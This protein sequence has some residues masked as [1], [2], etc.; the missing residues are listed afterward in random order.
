MDDLDRAIV[1]ALQDGV[2]VCE[3]PFAAA[4]DALGIGE[5]ALI[6]HLRRL[7][8]GGVLTRFGPMFDAERLGG[9]VSLAAMSVPPERLDAVAAQV[10]GF[11]EVAHN[12]ER[13]HALNLWFVLATEASDAI[14]RVIEAIASHT[15][16][17]V[18]DMPKLEEYYIGL[19][20]RT[21]KDPGGT[22]VKHA[23]ETTAS[24]AG[25]EHPARDAPMR[26]EGRVGAGLCGGRRGAGGAG[27]MCAHAL[28][29]TSI[30]SALRRPTSGG[31]LDTVDRAIVAATQEGLPL[32]PRPCHAVA[33]KL[34]LEPAQVMRR[35]QRMLDTGAVRRIAA[36]PNHYAL[37]YRANGMSVWNVGDAEVSEAGRAI[38]AL[39][40]V[41]HCYRRPRHPPFWPYNLFAMVH[42][43]TRTEV[44]AHVAEI[45]GVLG[46]RC[47]AHEV[48]Y[49]RRILKKAGLR[50]K[51]VD[52]SSART[53][54]NE[55]KKLDPPSDA[56]VDGPGR[57]APDPSGVRASPGNAGVSPA[58]APATDPSSPIAN[59][60]SLQAGRTR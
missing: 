2:E 24:R 4:A 55:S 29:T 54:D 15:G 19:R 25:T 10:N 14:A 8:A 23:H 41:S 40:F 30:G 1:D 36:V 42:G 34:G 21:G 59:S 18:Y 11:D 53:A 5:T 39:P 45:G 50:L 46:G 20:F 7:L 27:A 56:A 35:L 17:P 38:G 60:R 58:S 28:D 47:C 43:R 48:L 52:R 51:T 13:E 57:W 49:S 12:Y 37:G 6:E 22:V 32:V 16:Y 33:E 44:E 31:P 26:G 9:A 3:R